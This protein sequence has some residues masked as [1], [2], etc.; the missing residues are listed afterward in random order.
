M[1]LLFQIF[2]MWTLYYAGFAPFGLTLG[3]TIA[4]GIM[5]AYKGLEAVMKSR[6]DQLKNSQGEN[7]K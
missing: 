4:A 1:S 6:R 7:R 3:F 2:L 5:V